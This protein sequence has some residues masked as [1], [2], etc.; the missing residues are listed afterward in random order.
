M[1]KENQE[2]YVGY[3]GSRL[4]F[5]QDLFV[6]ICVPTLISPV[7]NKVRCTLSIL[8]IKFSSLPTPT[9]KSPESS[10]II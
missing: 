6:Q 9:P 5:F 10:K 2:K 8:M 4:E 1:T 3:L 7:S